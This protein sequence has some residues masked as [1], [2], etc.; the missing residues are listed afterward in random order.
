MLDRQTDGVCSM[1][2][3]LHCCMLRVSGR[4]YVSSVVVTL[5]ISNFTNIKKVLY[6]PTDT[7]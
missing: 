1:H 2:K 3:V 7:Q 6:L 5:V 4:G